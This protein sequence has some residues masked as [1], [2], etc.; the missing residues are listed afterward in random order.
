MYV[1]RVHNKDLELNSLS[2]FGTVSGKLP[3]E[4]T[5]HIYVTS[6]HQ[7]CT[8]FDDKRNLPFRVMGTDFN[9][10]DAGNILS[11]GK[12]KSVYVSASSVFFGKRRGVRKLKSV[13]RTSAELDLTQ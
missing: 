12:R 13:R 6:S 7:F 4:D 2:E 8:L 10:Q 9:S 3:L 5:L 11:C 1:N